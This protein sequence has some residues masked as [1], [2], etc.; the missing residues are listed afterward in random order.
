MSRWKAEGVTGP[1]PSRIPEGLEVVRGGSCSCSAAS[2]EFL[3]IINWPRLL[4]CS[5]GL[6]M[7]E[8]GVGGGREQGTRLLSA[9]NLPS[10]DISG[11][12]SFPPG[13]V[14]NRLCYLWMCCVEALP[15]HPLGAAFL[16]WGAS[17]ALGQPWLCPFR[18][19]LALLSCLSSMLLET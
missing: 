10:P 19:M 2:S 9:L 3:Q 6:E 7:E 5:T 18:T 13:S 16:G 15:R 14:T 12:R 8:V 1:L 4:L 11:K 17:Q